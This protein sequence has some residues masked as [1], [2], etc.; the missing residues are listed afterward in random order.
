MSSFWDHPQA[1]AEVATA[2]ESGSA[3]SQ[4][5]QGHDR[6]HADERI[7]VISPT[8]VISAGDLVEQ[9]I[10]AGQKMISAMSGSIL[11]SL[12]SM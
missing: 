2:F 10:T 1:T 8:M 5:G 3:S 12:T 7:P 4:R 6:I 11:T 9:D